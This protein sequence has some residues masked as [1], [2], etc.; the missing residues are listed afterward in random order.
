MTKN[1]IHSY[2]IIATAQ[3]HGIS[4]RI[5]SGRV[6]VLECG[7]ARLSDGTMTPY[8]QW[9]DTTGWDAPTFY[10]WLGY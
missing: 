7:M 4:V 5:D 1:T 9:R 2:D 8:E 6:L 10:S 3:Q